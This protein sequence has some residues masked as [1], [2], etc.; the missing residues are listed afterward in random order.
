[1]RRHIGILLVAI[2]M[3]SFMAASSNAPAFAANGKTI[4]G[5]VRDNGLIE[6]AEG[7]MV[8]IEMDKLGEEVAALV[9]KKVE[10]AGEFEER[11][12]GTRVIKVESYKILE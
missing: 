8:I 6:T 2:F 4:T 12:G 5:T 1:M 9:G 3:F 7:K 11:Y 10:V